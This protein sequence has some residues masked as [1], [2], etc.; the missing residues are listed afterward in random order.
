MLAQ[1]L[2]IKHVYNLK[3][4]Q[5][6][7][8]NLILQCYFLMSTKSTNSLCHYRYR[9]FILNMVKGELINFKDNGSNNMNKIRKCESSFN[10]IISEWPHQSITVQS[11]KVNILSETKVTRH[12][13]WNLF[14]N[15]WIL[16]KPNVHKAF[17]Y[18]L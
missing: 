4:Q 9:Q 8:T 1:C 6:V 3:N 10:H 15:E 16:I 12:W 7:K 11:K 14:I 17:A 18:W 5:H 13:H 2:M